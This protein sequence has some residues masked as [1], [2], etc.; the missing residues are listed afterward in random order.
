MMLAGFRACRFAA[1][2]ICRWM[3]SLLRS[4]VRIPVSPAKRFA[5]LPVIL[6]IAFAHNR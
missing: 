6:H 1:F 2:A 3:A 5:V 4:F